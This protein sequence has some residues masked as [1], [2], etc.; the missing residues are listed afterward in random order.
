VNGER[1]GQSKLNRAQVLEIIKA[2]QESGGK[3]FWGAKKLA[4]KYGV[5]PANINAIVNGKSWGHLR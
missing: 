3:Y 5:D 4:E 1:N 2:K